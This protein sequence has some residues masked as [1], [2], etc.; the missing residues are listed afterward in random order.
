MESEKHQRQGRHSEAHAN[1]H[2]GFLL[3]KGHRRD[4]SLSQSSLGNKV[5]LALKRQAE[6]HW[7]GLREE[8]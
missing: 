7:G 4:H 1:P 8:A 6:L 5:L 3:L 2:A